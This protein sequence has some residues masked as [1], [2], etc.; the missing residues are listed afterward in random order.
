VVFAAWSFLQR[1]FFDAFHT[2]YKDVEDFLYCLIVARTV[3][4]KL[5]LPGDHSKGKPAGLRNL[6]FAFRGYRRAPIIDGA[7]QTEMNHLLI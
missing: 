3:G 7:V 1:N 6:T 4:V 5:C 2:P